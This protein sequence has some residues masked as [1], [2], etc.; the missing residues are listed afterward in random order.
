MAWP[1]DTPATACPRVAHARALLTSTLTFNLPNA[2]CLGV[3]GRLCVQLQGGCA[4]SQHPAVPPCPWEFRW[5][6]DTAAGDVGTEP[7]RSGGAAARACGSG[8]RGHACV[9][10]AVRCSG[11]QVSRARG[12]EGGADQA[13]APPEGRKW[14]CKCKYTFAC[15]CKCRW[16]CK[17]FTSHA[18]ASYAAFRPVPWWGRWGCIGE[19]AVR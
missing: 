18:C 17:G 6:A 10:T 11:C 19:D 2:V 14:K 16:Q 1:S 4:A 7:Q 13:V 8:R 12:G 3:S 15:G 9:R 5:N